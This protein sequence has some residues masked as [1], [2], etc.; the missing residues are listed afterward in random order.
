MAVAVL[1]GLTMGWGLKRFLADLAAV[2]DDAAPRHGITTGVSAAERAKSIRIAIDPKSGP[3]DFVRP[4][5]INPLRARDGGV[6]V[7]AGQTEGSVDLCKLAGLTP[8][9]ATW[10]P[11]T[12]HR[13][14]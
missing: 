10:M 2:L 3:D 8:A 13:P 9:A 11:S 4:G 6:L 7:R 14:D 12:S 5:H 1:F